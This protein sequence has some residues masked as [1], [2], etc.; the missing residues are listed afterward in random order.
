MAR[1]A[2]FFRSFDQDSAPM[3]SKTFDFT[4]SPT[5]FHS[6]DCNV[7][8]RFDWNFGPDK[9][10]ASRNTTVINFTPTKITAGSV[11]RFTFEVKTFDLSLLHEY[12]GLWPEG[13]GFRDTAHM[14]VVL[15]AKFLDSAGAIQNKVIHT[16]ELR[17]AGNRCYET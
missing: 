17:R 9:K 15:Y 6:E 10:L 16:E 7:T 5:S 1:A 14:Q 2:C 4:A 8:G 11:V 12:E 3:P 13:Q